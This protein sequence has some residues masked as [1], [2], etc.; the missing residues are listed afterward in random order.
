MFTRSQAC[1]LLIVTSKW[2]GEEEEELEPW[3]DF[4]RHGEIRK[5]H[6]DSSGV[7]RSLCLSV[8][9]QISVLAGGFLLRRR[10]SSSII[11]VFAEGKASQ[12]ARKIPDL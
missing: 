6:L 7:T 5:S 11:V 8:A 1:V 9:S 3:G 10:I 12:S 2:G 4:S